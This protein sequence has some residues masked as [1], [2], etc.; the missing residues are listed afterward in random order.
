VKG[1]AVAEVIKGKVWRFGDGIT[2]DHIIPGRYF[3]LRGDIRALAAHAMEDVD[4]EFAERARPGDLIVAGKNFGQGSSREYAA[5]VLRERGI[6]AVVAQSFARIFFRNAINVGLFP[7]VCDT[8]GIEAGDV[9]EID[10]GA[11]V[12]RDLTRGFSRDFAPLPPWML[13]IVQEGGI[14]PYIL[15]H[16]GL[17]PATGG[18]DE[19]VQGCCGAS[20]GGAGG[21]RRGNGAGH[22]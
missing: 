1:G 17:G 9:L 14:V 6:R 13:R 3:H 12:V 10:L 7:V 18:D 8:R 2:T 11:G 4:P 15:A 5:L 21:I 16:G 20:P 19:G 22:L